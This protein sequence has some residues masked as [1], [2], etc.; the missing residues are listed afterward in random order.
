M[1]LVVDETQ[2]FFWVDGERIDAIP[3][4]EG[5]GNARVPSC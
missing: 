2:S 4:A 1:V 5:A 3:Y